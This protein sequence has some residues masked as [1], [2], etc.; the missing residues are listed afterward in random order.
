[1][2]DYGKPGITEGPWE[3]RETAPH[4]GTWMVFDSAGLMVC[5][6]TNRSV[7]NAIADDH[8]AM[9]ITKDSNRKR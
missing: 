2:T 6:V 3:V 7:A 9:R 1:M 4:I 5:E 8:N